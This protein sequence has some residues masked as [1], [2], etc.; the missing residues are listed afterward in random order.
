M[1]DVREA[2]IRALDEAIRQRRRWEEAVADLQHRVDNAQQ[3]AEMG[4]YYWH[5]PT[6]TNRWSDQ[7][8]RIFGY[9]PQSRDM[10][11]ASYLA[12]CHPDDKERLVEIHQHSYATGEP[13]QM[14]HR[15]IRTDGQV[16]H[17]LCNGE[18]VMD[19]TGAPVSMR[20]TAIDIT[21]EVEVDQ[22]R[23]TAESMLREERTRRKAALEIN[24][25]VVQGLTAAL[26]ALE[27]DDLDAA[28]MFVRRTLE[29]SRR[30]VTDMTGAPEHAGQTADAS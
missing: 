25:N 4:D 30:L 29:A 13:Y 11:Y 9:E 18:V 26:Y 19:E 2:A 20:G 27:S 8:Y 15:I 21:G 14:T 23:E 10:D 17:L 7:L 16:R 5:I 1:S 22:S 24:D 12:H 3:I 28:G 6:D